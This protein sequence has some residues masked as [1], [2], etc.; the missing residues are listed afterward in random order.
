MTD[1]YQLALFHRSLA[2]LCRSE[3]P[4]GRA[5]RMLEQDLGRGK[6]RAAAAA[7][8]AEVEKGTPLPVAYRRQAG[9]FPPLYAALIEA[10]AASGDL[11]GTL[12]EIAR[13]C[14]LKAEASARVRKVLAYPL[15]VV[16]FIAC[17]LFFLYEF[18]IPQFGAIYAQVDDRWGN[19]IEL[20]GITKLV[21]ALPTLLPGILALLA[22]LVLGLS[23]LRDP[24]DGIRLP[25]GV[26]MRLPVVGPL[27]LNASLMSLSATLA[28]L[29]RRGLPLDRALDLAAA[30]ADGPSVRRAAEAMARSAR[31]GSGL[32]D[33]ARDSGLL[34]PSMLWMLGT[35]E[36]QGYTPQALDEISGI[37]RD[38][39]T[40][41]MDTLASMIGP[42]AE[43]FLGLLVFFIVMGTFYPILRLQSALL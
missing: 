11:P 2:D 32:A 16:A 36:K 25:V 34:P 29:L 22:L 39:V 42:V 6:L 15:V 31:E 3:V 23:Y 27:R 21:F 35:A 28:I 30:A 26:W 1:H 5:F 9:A 7:L 37:C 10:G 12:A 4:L 33:A 19:P 17:L 14:S 43:V 8:A 38:R 20:P 24:V 13:I 18:V 40:R 41:E